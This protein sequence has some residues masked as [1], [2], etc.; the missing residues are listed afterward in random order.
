MSKKNYQVPEAEQKNVAKAMAKNQS[1]SLKYSI[2]IIRAI[3]GMP[4]SKAKTFLEDVIT[5]HRALPLHTYIKKIGHRKGA[6]QEGS[7]TGRYP[8]R[9]AQVFLSLLQTVKAN[10]DYRKMNSENLLIHNMFASQGVARISHQAQGR[11]SG[12]R[13]KRKSAHLEI[14]VVEGKK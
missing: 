12:K 2:E 3:K 6:A 13:R 11:I 1:V 8:E 9:T 14:V 10:A 4:L 5:H 7:K